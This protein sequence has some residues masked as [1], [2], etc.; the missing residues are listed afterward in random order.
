MQ[1]AKSLTT[2]PITPILVSMTLPMIL[3]LFS[4]NAF[5]L[6]DAYFVGKLGSTEL[7]ALG[8]AMPVT[9]VLGAIGM[10]LSI[11]A[12]AVISRALGEQDDEKVRRLTTDSLTLALAF[13]GGFVVLGLL[14]MDGLFRAMGAQG[15]VLELVKSYMIIWYVG[16]LF[17]IVPFVGNSATRASGDTKTP[18]LIMTGMVILNILLEPVLIFGWAMVPALGLRGAAYAGYCAGVFAGGIPL[19]AP[20]GRDAHCPSAEF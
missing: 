14:T 5:N 17:L 3:G 19:G 2:G 12:S 13:A 6:I 10:G 11:G 1:S 7:A 20:P 8:F 18:A 15:E 16:V 4:M 9:L